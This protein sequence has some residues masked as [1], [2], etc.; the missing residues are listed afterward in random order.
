V[1]SCNSWS[2]YVVFPAKLSFLMTFFKYKKMVVPWCENILK[3]GSFPLSPVAG[4][5]TLQVTSLGLA[6]AENTDCVA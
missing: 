6:V 1:V 4:A 5:A 2:P 3:A